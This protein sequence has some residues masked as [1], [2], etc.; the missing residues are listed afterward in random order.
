MRLCSKRLS[1]D[2]FRLLRIALAGTMNQQHREV[3][4]Y[5]QGRNH[6]LCGRLDAN[7][8]ESGGVVPHTVG[9]ALDRSS[10]PEAR[11]LG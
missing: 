11:R 4:G 10:Y 3:T 2:L 9:A 6:A 8:S 7:A 5:L 1:F